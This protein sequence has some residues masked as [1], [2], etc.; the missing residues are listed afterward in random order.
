MT[1]YVLLI[2]FTTIKQY[3]KYK[4]CAYITAR[5]GYNTI[6]PHANPE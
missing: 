2:Y 3:N 1:C 6:I 4:K 5:L